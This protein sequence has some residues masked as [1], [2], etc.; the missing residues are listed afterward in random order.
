VEDAMEKFI[1]GKEEVLVI[2][3]NQEEVLSMQSDLLVI[4]YLLEART[5]ALKKLMYVP[6]HAPIV[7][8]VKEL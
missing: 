4:N 5:D 3:L 6:N 2:L 8:E 7:E 1:N